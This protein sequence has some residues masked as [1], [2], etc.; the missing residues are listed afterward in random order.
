[1]ADVDHSPFYS[2]EW[3][4]DRNERVMRLVGVIDIAAAEHLFKGLIDL[5]SRRLVID[6]TDAETVDLTALEAVAEIEDRLGPG[7]VTV[8]HPERC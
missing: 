1:M 4:Q 6:L 7:R 2:F 3:S 8:L 5:G